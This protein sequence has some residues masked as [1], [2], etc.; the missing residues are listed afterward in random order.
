MNLSRLAAA[1]LIGSTSLL[2]AC[3]DLQ[4]HEHEH[5]QS[6]HFTPGLGEIMAQTAVRHTKLWFAGQARNWE[7]AA[8]EVDE[9][10]E[11]FA[12]AGKYHP[13]HK[14]IKQPV[15]E[16]IA[17]YMDRPL[18]GM[19]QAIKD[20]NLPM[21]IENYNAITAACNACHQGTEFGFNMVTQPSFN[22]FA[23]QAFGS[24]N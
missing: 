10:R 19:E 7:L 12:D 11:G 22:P 13:T 1:I 2:L 18:A 24:G 21:F 4:H 14:Q 5:Q 15:P 16:L 23:N 6:A 9:L 3:A 8:Y 17:Q 20:K